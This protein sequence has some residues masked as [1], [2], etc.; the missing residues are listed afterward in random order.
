MTAPAKQSKSY[1]GS[2]FWIGVGSRRDAEAQRDKY[3]FRHPGSFFFAQDRLEPGSI[4]CGTIGR[5]VPA[6]AG[7]T[8]N[9][10]V[11]ASLREAV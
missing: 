10:R 8:E 6:F 1:F 11:S 4:S 9:L 7:K 2:L 3:A 5:W